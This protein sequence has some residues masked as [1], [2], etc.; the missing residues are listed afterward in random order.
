MTWRCFFTG[1]IWK[2]SCIG[3]STKT[4]MCDRCRSQKTESYAGDGHGS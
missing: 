4:H 1:C 3:T 2:L